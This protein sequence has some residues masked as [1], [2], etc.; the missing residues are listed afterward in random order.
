MSFKRVM[1]EVYITSLAILNGGRTCL[2]NPMNQN[3]F[4]RQ[5]TPQKKYKQVNI[6]LQ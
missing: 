3:D 1:V 5:S 4:I 2:D 6:V